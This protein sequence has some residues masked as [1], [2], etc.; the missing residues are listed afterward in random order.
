[1]RRPVCTAGLAFVVILFVVMLRIP[2]R[3]A[4]YEAFE[5]EEVVALG[6][7]SWKE[8]RMSGGEKTLTVSLEQVIVLKPEKALQVQK[9]LSGSD[10]QFKQTVITNTGYQAFIKEITENRREDYALEGAQEIT[11]LIG[12]LDAEPKGG[13]GVRMGSWILL[14]GTFRPMKHAT[15][16]GEFDAADYYRIMGQQGRLMKSSV[17]AESAFCD[18]FREGLFRIRN[19]LSLL[20][21]ACCPEREA[22]VMKAMLLGEKGMLDQELKSLYQ[23][24]GIIHILSISGLHLTL[25]G[26]GFHNLLRKCRVPKKL[27]LFAATAFMLC[28]GTM[29]GMGVSV[30]RALVMFSFQ[31]AAKYLGRTYDMPTALAVAALTLLLQK[32]FYLEHS[33]FLFSFG[34]VCAIAVLLPA[35]TENFLWEHRALRELHAGAVLSAGTLPVYLF[36]YYEFPPYSI[37][38]NLLVIPCMSLVLVSGVLTLV[39]GAWY[40]PLGRVFAWPARGLLLLYEKGCEFC[41]RLS[42]HRWITGCPEGWQILLFLVILCILVYINEKLPKL[43]FWQIFLLALLVLTCRTPDPLEIHMVDVGQGDCILIKTPEREALLIDGG[44]TDRKDVD[45]YQI[46][47]FLKYQGVSELK[48]VAVTHADSDHMNGICGML[49]NYQTNGIRIGMLLLPDI[50]KESRNEN[51]L[52]LETLAAQN[53][54]P[55]GY[56]GA[57]KRFAIGETRLTCLHPAA[58]SYY[59]DINAGSTVLYVQYRSFTAL[60]TGDLE[61][62]GERQLLDEI[63]TE[64]G[65]NLPVTLLKVAHHGSGGSTSQEFLERTSPLLALI[66]CGRGNSYGHP[67]AETMRR[68]EDAGT[69][70]YTTMNCGAVSVSVSR[71]GRLRVKGYLAREPY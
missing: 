39:G 40:L 38:L 71:R 25:L 67:H 35:A 68:L 57:G 44:S 37:L 46:V 18:P 2:H 3:A 20:L 12:Y 65:G 62:E 41:L 19:Y 17:L 33:G 28:Y 34:A 5:R 45:V 49:E 27:N 23:Q 55:V 56:L 4:T 51:Y 1:M 30:A 69:V 70:C 58:G 26:M 24:N 31:M 42:E 6:N 8:Y 43:V 7:V 61:G 14:K 15:N 60:F 54:I 22:V 59:A 64:E 32:P 66:S 63:K 48:A 13:D 50:S 52:L 47:P 21:E 11:G 29:V 53:G 9:I 36:F 16:P 10:I